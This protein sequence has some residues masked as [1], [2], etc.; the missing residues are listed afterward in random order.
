MDMVQTR[1][2]RL[3]TVIEQTLDGSYFIYEPEAGQHHIA[4]DSPEWFLWLSERTSLSFKCSQ[5]HFTAR[6]EI[7]K[8][9]EAQ[10]EKAYWYAYQ[11]A[12]RKLHKRY[13]GT[14]EKLTLALLEETAQT[15]QE[16]IVSTLP[17]SQLLTTQSRQ[18][19]PPQVL[20][21]GSFIFQC[22]DD[23]LSIQTPREH[24]SLTRTQAAE[25]LRYLYDQQRRFLQKRV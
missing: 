12:Y 19:P 5:G 10:A 15:L 3:N 4:P 2:A 6:K 8:Q 16:E 18:K 21:L 17:P 9:G 13:L 22:T 20:T 14:T 11:R 24:H 25:L 23:G 1:E 7:R